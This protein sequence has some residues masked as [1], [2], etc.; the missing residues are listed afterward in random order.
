MLFKRVLTLFLSLSA[1]C[2]AVGA[3]VNI[4]GRVVDDTNEPVVAASVKVAGTA[5][6]T[7]TNTEGN[8]KLS[9]AARDTALALRKCVVR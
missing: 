8:Y 9:V 5:T 6:G 2:V 7:T 1:I 3:N 4:R